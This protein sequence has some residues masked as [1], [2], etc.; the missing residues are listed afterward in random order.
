MTVPQVIESRVPASLTAPT[1]APVCDWTTN[2]GVED[3]A[4]AALD[5]LRRANTDKA[6]IRAAQEDGGHE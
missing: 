3:C 5:A 2:G 6:A 1:P 4:D